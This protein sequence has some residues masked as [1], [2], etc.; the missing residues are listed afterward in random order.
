LKARVA[1]T[2]DPRVTACRRGRMQRTHIP[3][4]RRAA[5]EI[6]VT[7]RAIGSS[8]HKERVC[9][10]LTQQ[11]VGELSGP[12]GVPVSASPALDGRDC[13]DRAIASCRTGRTIYYCSCTWS[14]SIRSSRAWD[15]GCG[16]DGAVQTSWARETV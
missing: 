9:A 14:A 5:I 1:E 15:G 6:R 2:V 16:F 8:P 11:T 4:C 7:Q 10:W 12:R 3:A 13:L